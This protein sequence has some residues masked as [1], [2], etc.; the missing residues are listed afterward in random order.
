MLTLRRCIYIFSHFNLTDFELCSC[1]EQ[2]VWILCGYY[3]LPQHPLGKLGVQTAAIIRFFF[4]E[5][6]ITH[7]F[8]HI[9]LNNEAKQNSNLVKL[10]G[11]P[12]GST[13]KK[14]MFL[15]ESMFSD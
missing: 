14:T 15:W 7:R 13:W 12:R 9:K 11:S 1:I 3:F 10:S 4:S 8:I 6:L 2:L 5:L